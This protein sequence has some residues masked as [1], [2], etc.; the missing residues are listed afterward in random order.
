MAMAGVALAAAVAAGLARD[1]TPAVPAESATPGTRACLAPDAAVSLDHVI[2]AVPDLEAAAEAYRA[3]GFTLKEGR[4]HPNGLLNKH[5]KLAD[6]SELELMSLAREPGDDMARRYAEI[7]ASGGGGAYAAF[8]APQAAVL[9]AAEE[10]G[11]AAEESRVDA[12]RYVTLPG[13]GDEAVF[14]LETSAATTDPDSVLIHANGAAGLTEA[15]VESGEGLGRLLVALGGVACDAV[16]LPDGRESRVF[17]VANGFVVVAPP[18]EGRAR[19][20]GASLAGDRRGEGGEGGAT[21]WLPPSR[22]LGVWLGVPAR[23]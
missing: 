14:F 13:A 12:T 10:V 15:W 19:L 23:R 1:G 9:T 7:L 8:R 2:L 20:L 18:G 5:V 17:G 6:G 3:L 21:R 4:L 16:R 11:V 22:T